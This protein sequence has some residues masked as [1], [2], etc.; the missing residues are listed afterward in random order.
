MD[1]FKIGLLNTV[2]SA[3]V[4]LLIA[5]AIGVVIGIFGSCGSKILRVIARIYVE[6]FQDTPL[7][8]QM[9][10]LYYLLSYGGFW[11]DKSFIPGATQILLVGMISLGLYHGAYIGEVFRA[12]I[13]AVPEGQFEASYAQGFSYG[14]TMKRIIFPQM[15]KIILPPFVNQVVSLI[16]NTSCLYIVG[17]ADLIAT[18][19]NFVT[20]ESTGG[21]YGP[22]YLLAGLFFFIICFPLS[23]LSGKWEQKLKEREEESQ[24][25]MHGIIDPNEKPQD[26]GVLA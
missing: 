16:K 25:H 19:Y 4:G 15:I 1:A 14:D 8:L 20:G 10:F 24:K 11:Q 2:E 9:L 3:A 13:S 7:M 23:S 12:G 22:A 18:T 6:F 21:A 17:G 26:G 5:V